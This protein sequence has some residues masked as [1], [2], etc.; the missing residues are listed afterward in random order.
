MARLI[1]HFAVLLA[2]SFAQVLI[3][4]CPDL[5]SPGVPFSLPTYDPETGYAPALAYKYQVIEGSTG[6]ELT[7]VNG[8]ALADLVYSYLDAQSGPNHFWQCVYLNNQCGWGAY[9]GHERIQCNM[10]ASFKI[11]LLIV[12]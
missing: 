7:D 2:S 9:A 4:P 8:D 12:Q 3:A 11:V 6:L 5:I 1:L 10:G